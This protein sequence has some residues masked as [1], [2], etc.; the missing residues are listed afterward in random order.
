[1]TIEMATN[2]PHPLTKASYRSGED[3]FSKNSMMPT[4]VIGPVI[5]GRP[6]G[7][8]EL[9]GLKMPHLPDAND[10]VYNAYRQNKT[11]GHGNRHERVPPLNKHAEFL[12]RRR[13]L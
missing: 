8:V 9:N 10:A 5:G 1:M 7:I 6:M 2:W 12:L 13:A 4:V 3:V 11:D